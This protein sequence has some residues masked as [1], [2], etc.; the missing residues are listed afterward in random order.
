MI[1]KNTKEIEIDE[2]IVEE[3]TT[4]LQSKMVIGSFEDRKPSALEF[5]AWL[6]ALNVELCGDSTCFNHFKGYRFYI[7]EVDSKVT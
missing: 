6:V 1:K 3:E 7:L 4:K 5:E 2:P